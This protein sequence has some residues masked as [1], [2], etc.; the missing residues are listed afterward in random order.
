MEENGQTGRGG[1]R[2]EERKWGGREGG[3]ESQRKGKVGHLVTPGFREWQ[4]VPSPAR[5]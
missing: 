4:E 3:G 1:S 2:R 5:Y